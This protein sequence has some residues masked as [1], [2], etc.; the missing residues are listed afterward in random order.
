LPKQFRGIVYV[1]CYTLKIRAG[2]GTS[3]SSWSSESQ[4]QGCSVLRLS[5]GDSHGERREG[6]GASN[7]C[8]QRLQAVPMGCDLWG[9]EVV[10]VSEIPSS[11]FRASSDERYS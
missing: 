10:W 6:D 2:E 4:Q 7:H 3:S 5:A 11:Y 1:T 8:S 9:K